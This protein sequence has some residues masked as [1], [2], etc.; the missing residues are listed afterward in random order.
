MKMN[1]DE[2]RFAMIK[3]SLITNLFVIIIIIHEL[4]SLKM[5]RP[6]FILLKVNLDALM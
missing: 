4:A 2:K 6:E 1:K 5:S 3:M